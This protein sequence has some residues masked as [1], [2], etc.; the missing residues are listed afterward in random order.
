MAYTCA[1]WARHVLVV[2]GHSQKAWTSTKGCWAASVLLKSPAV[3]CFGKGKMLWGAEQQLSVGC[4]SLCDG[5]TSLLAW[6]CSDFYLYLLHYQRVVEGK[7]AE[8]NKS[9]HLCR[10]DSIDRCNHI[11][12][13]H[14]Q[15]TPRRRQY[16]SWWWVRAGDITL[17]SHYCHYT[18]WVGLS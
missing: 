4:H 17:G 15:P 11:G 14:H 8:W 9:F 5:Q 16:T 10:K 1:M 7:L 13:S 12:A 2:L 6:Q 3:A 18:G